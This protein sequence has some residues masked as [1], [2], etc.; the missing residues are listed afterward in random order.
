[1]IS[2]RRVLALGL[3]GVLIGCSSFSG[4]AE[5]RPG[6]AF[7]PARRLLYQDGWVPHDVYMKG[8]VRVDPGF[9]GVDQRLRSLGLVE[10]EGCAKD[11][12]QCVFN[13]RR[14]SQ[15]MRLTTQGDK[16]AEMRVTDVSGVCP[17]SR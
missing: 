9:T 16:L 6:M 7:N 12:G 15:C 8:L 17:G 1:M 2:F 5:V 14:G 13:Y 10:V 11:T 3:T 4:P